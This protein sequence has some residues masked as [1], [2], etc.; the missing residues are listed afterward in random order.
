MIGLFWIRI[1]HNQFPMCNVQ[2]CHIISKYH[3]FSFQ[4]ASSQ[5][6]SSARASTGSESKSRTAGSDYPL[7]GPHPIKITVAILLFLSVW[8]AIIL[9]AHVHKKVQGSLSG[10][11]LG[12]VVI[13]AKVARQYS[14]SSLMLLLKCNF[15]Y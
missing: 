10:C 13:K 1:S 14:I 6:S 15:F 3:H 12:L 4:V 11:S 8:T 2:Q 9:G 7:C 5:C